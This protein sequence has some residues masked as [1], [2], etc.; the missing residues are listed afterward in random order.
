MIAFNNNYICPEVNYGSKIFIKDGRHPVIEQKLATIDFIPN[1][2]E[3]DLESDYVYII[4]GP[5]M[6]GK[7]TYL[8][9][10]A[11]IVLMT[12]IGSFVPASSAS[13]GIV[14]RI[15]TRIGSSDNLARGQST[16]L[17]EMLETA[18]I[19]KYA[20]KK[21]F[22]IMDEIGRGTS[23]FDGLSI[24]WSVL[25]YI[26]NKKLL[27]AK[28]LFAT[29]YHELTDLEKKTGVKNYS[30]AISEDDGKITFLHKII[31]GAAEKS[32]GIHVAGLA[33]LPDEVIYFAEGLLKK[34]ENNKNHEKINQGTSDGQLEL[35][36]LTNI[37][38]KKKKDEIVESL[39]FIDLN[40]ITPIDA[41]NI[42]SDLQKKL[43][44]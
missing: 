21:S 31:P 6:S 44:K 4:T 36:D 39:K 18:N 42:I 7:S 10:N 17:V 30:I 41:L 5:N 43:K 16:F 11:L 13:I 27:G 37:K 25:E 24:A 40:R 1:D 20:T 8:R 12:Q 23:T 34:L 35:F 2:L 28:T 33:N 15:F 9:Q 14:D 22:I 38:E 29:H 19:L 26:L 32:Y 3:M